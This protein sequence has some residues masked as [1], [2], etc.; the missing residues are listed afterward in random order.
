[1]FAMSS[2]VEVTGDQQVRAQ[3]ADA[4]GRPCRL[5]CCIEGP[6]SP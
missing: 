5:P 6:R 1:V 3:R 4:V 2:N